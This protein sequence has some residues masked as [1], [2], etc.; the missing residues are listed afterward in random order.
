MTP[1]EIKAHL[2]LKGIKH[3]ELAKELG[4]HKTAITL[5][6]NGNGKSKR[7]QEAIAKAINKP[8]NEVWKKKSA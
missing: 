6:I 2:I 7:I 8:F 4:V 5:V 1:Q 3:C